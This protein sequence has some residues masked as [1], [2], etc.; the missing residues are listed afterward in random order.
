MH[1]PVLQKEVIQYLNPKPN[2]NFIDC[3][4]GEGGHARAI[5]ERNGAEGKV[6]GIDLDPDQIKNVQHPVLGSERLILV[7]DNFV[8]LKKIVQKH[9]F[10]SVNGILFDLG[11][12]SW[13]LEESGRGFTFRKDEPLDMRYQVT[14][15]RRSPEMCYGIKA[16]EI[17]NKWPQK[18]IEKVLKNYG[19]ERFA[20]KISQRIVE[21]RKI[22]PIETTFQLIEIVKKATPSWYG[23]KKIHP[24]TKTFQA[25]RIAVNDELNNLKKALPQALEVL[26]P[27]A[28]L[29]I[30][31]FHG[32]E[33]KIV[34]NF[35]KENY[36]K[37]L[38]KILFK[39]PIRSSRVE[40]TVNPRA[41]SA[42]L[43]AA[44]K[45]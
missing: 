24:A 13:H 7:C 16:E 18:E 39:K 31:S 3:T 29:V 15:F 40:I 5:L 32:L 44:E 38:L 41:R 35:F 33:D 27:K 20:K 45:T 1:I 25:L 19:E 30:I 9:N 14:R 26:Q 8:N 17:V 10:Q 23:H 4:F 12:S 22:K 37:G 34:K 28:R 42:R 6:L 11:M 43:R 36:E 21:Q 2:E